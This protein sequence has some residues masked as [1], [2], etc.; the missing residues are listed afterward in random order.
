MRMSL[1]RMS[2][3][4]GLLVML[5]VVVSL[6][7]ISASAGPRA[8]AT[9]TANGGM[10]GCSNLP[11]VPSVSNCWDCF[12]NLLA[13]CDENNPTEARRQACYAAANNFF[14][15]CLSRVPGAR[16]VRPQPA[17]PRGIDSVDIR[18]QYQFE[19]SVPE[20]TSIDD[21]RIFVRHTDN[22]ENVQT[23]FDDFW[24]FNT[25]ESDMVLIILD[26]DSL[27][28]SNDDAIGIVAA[29][30]SGNLISFAH[31]RYLPIV[32]SFDINGDGRFDALDRIDAMT[33]FQSGDIDQME[34]NRILSAN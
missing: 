14:T 32:D 5:T 15:W 8:S 1:M 28:L 4:S 3:V 31:A 25:G 34:L 30:Q 10:A 9:G 24:V 21:I 18:S 22:G 11:N 20:G 2:G 33:H 13:D 7:A 17:G 29:V 16:P 23:R 19:L 12:Q 27:P 6:M 26:T